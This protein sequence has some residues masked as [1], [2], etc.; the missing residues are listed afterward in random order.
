M[1]WKEG[2]NKSKAC[3]ENLKRPEDERKKGNAEE[4]ELVSK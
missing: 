3:E 1:N 2:E 4:Y